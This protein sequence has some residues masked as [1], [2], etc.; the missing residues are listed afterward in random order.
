MLYKPVEDPSTPYWLEVIWTACQGQ[1][2]VEWYY[3]FRKKYATAPNCKQ[4]SNESIPWVEAGGANPGT[5]DTS[6][7]MTCN[8]TAV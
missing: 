7:S 8:V 5:C 3:L 6:G 2:E 1:D 4:F